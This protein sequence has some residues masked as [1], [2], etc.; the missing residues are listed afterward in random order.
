MIEIYEVYYLEASSLGLILSTRLRGE[1][2]FGWDYSAESKLSDNSGLGLSHLI[3]DVPLSVY[4]HVVLL[5]LTIVNIEA[6]C[7][8]FCE[9]R[10]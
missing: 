8:R 9:R 7:N 4:V 1:R 2:V 10:Q 6:C 3:D 5:I